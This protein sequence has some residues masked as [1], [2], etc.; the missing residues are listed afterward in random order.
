[1]ENPNLKWMMTGG[2]PMT[3]WKPPCG[4]LINQQLGWPWNLQ[5]EN[6]VPGG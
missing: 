6:T 5:F 1:M 4:E 3:C 2:S